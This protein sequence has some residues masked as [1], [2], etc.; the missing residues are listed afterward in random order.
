M[1]AANHGATTDAPPVRI[2]LR[3]SVADS[4]SYPL[5]PLDITIDVWNLTSRPSH[6]AAFLFSN[7]IPRIIELQ[8]SNR[9]WIWSPDG[10]E[11]RIIDVGSPAGTFEVK[12]WPPCPE[13]QPGDRDHVRQVLRLV[14]YQDLW[15]A[16]DAQGRPLIEEV[17]LFPKPGTYVTQLENTFLKV[18][19]NRLTIEVKEPTGRDRE[20][21]EYLLRC[22]WPFFVASDLFNL[23]ESARQEARTFVEQY[24]DTVYGPYA[25]FYLSHQEYREA[26]NDLAT[27]GVV[28]NESFLELWDELIADENFRLWPWVLKKK[29]EYLERLSFRRATRPI[30][31]LGQTLTAEQQKEIALEARVIREFLK[32]EYPYFPD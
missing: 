32:K 11:R 24:G 20:A 8:E 1:A 3:Q 25:R 27:S 19:S 5:L 15:W 23:E 2:T 31:R 22:K 21:Y 29:A 14:H 4:P 13:I 26:T 17:F 30:V 10:T 16:K 12:N 7:A 6:C 9:W 28:T 18:Q